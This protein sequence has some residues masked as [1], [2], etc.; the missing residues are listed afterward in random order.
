[1]VSQK[2]TVGRIAQDR[3]AVTTGTARSPGRLGRC[4][5]IS[6]SLR[7][8]AH[9]ASVEWGDQ[10]QIPGESELEQEAR[11]K[12]VRT[13]HSLQEGRGRSY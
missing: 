13:H 5:T 4:V 8:L 3:D 7:I 1:M 9:E 11:E 2:R 6:R 10:K 12:L